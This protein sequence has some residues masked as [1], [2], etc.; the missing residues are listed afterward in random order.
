MRQQKLKSQFEKFGFENYLKNT[1]RNCDLHDFLLAD[2][3][4]HQL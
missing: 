3:L 1:N 2:F 4:L